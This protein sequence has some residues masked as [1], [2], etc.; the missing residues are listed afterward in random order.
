MELITGKKPIEAEYGENKNIVFWVSNKV[1]TKEGVLEIL[2]KRLKGSFRDEI[3]KALR[4]AIRCTYRNPVL[5]PAMG[6]VVELLQQVDPC[7]FDRPF[8]EV[9][10]VG[11]YP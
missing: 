2:D 3:I 9:K 8:K 1:D 7:K 10:K 6:E 11:G 4:I 5:R